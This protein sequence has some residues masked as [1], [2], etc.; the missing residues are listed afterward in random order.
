MANNLILAVQKMEQMNTENIV[1][2]VAP[3]L[4]SPIPYENYYIIGVGAKELSETISAKVMIPK[5]KYNVNNPI[6]KGDLISF[7]GIALSKTKIVTNGLWVPF[8]K[9]TKQIHQEGLVIT[10]K[11]WKF[12]QGTPAKNY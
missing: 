11:K 12:T 4:T 9:A 5:N 10:I 2:D 3:V 8:S 7:K 1:V 6:K